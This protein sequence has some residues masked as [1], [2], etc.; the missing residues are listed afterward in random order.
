MDSKLEFENVT[1]IA[2]DTNASGL[3]LLMSDRLD[4]LSRLRESVTKNLS[5]I[6]NKKQIMVIDSGEQSLSQPFILSSDQNM[7]MWAKVLKKCQDLYVIM[8]RQG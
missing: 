7:L 5:L 8:W 6:K 1:P 2:I 3:F 4:E